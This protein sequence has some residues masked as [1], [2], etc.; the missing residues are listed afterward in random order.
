MNVRGRLARLE[1]LR[2]PENGGRRGVTRSLKGLDAG[3]VCD[4]VEAAV[5]DEDA[6]LLEAVLDEVEEVER[7]PLLRYEG[8]AEVPWLDDDG[9]QLFKTSWFTYWLW[10][11]G[12][13]SW[14]LPLRVPRVILEA[15][16]EEHALIAR[17][18]ESCRAALPGRVGV[19]G[20]V[21]CGAGRDMVSAKA[22][23]GPTHHHHYEYKPQNII[24][25]PGRSVPWPAD[26]YPDN[27][28][29]P[30]GSIMNPTGDDAGD[31]KAADRE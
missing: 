31:D 1:A 8:G 22:L 12:L 19:G 4:A 14:S 3:A 29:M 9:E 30:D 15:F 18:C 10:G 24:I 23:Y 26:S 13:G 28:V 27:C 17:R 16:N 21:V 5:A 25:S 6:D 11:L 20:C 7:T 2:G